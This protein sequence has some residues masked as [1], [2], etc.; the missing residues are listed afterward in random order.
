NRAR[1]CADTAPAPRSEGKW[2]R[3]G[4]RPAVQASSVRRREINPAIGFHILRHTLRIAPHRCLRQP[5]ATGPSLGLRES[6]CANINIALSL[7]QVM[8]QC[9]MIALRKALTPIICLGEK[10]MSDLRAN[11]ASILP[12]EKHKR[13]GRTNLRPIDQRKKHRD[14]TNFH[15]WL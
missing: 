3:F 6:R 4:E 9:I 15:S 8:M 5:A 2:K 1:K 11:R 10:K 14:L 7:L 12:A 13:S